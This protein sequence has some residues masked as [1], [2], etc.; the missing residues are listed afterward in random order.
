MPKLLLGLGVALLLAFA[1]VAWWLDGP[2]SSAS[3]GK[4]LDASPGA[5]YATKFTDLAG[6]ERA[7]AEWQH[8]TLLINF[9]ATWCGPCKEEMP[10]LTK[11]QAKYGAYG[12]QVIGIAVDSRL[13]VSNFAKSTKV[14]YPLFP[15]EARAIEFSR[16]AGNRLGLLPYT[17][18]MRPGGEVVFTKLGVVTEAEIAHLI[19]NGA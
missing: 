8:K 11:L 4:T 16:R 5:I 12:L 13:N 19:A 14:G 18:V 9:W 3:T 2:K 7:L 6:R 17:L 1:G 15:D 10:V